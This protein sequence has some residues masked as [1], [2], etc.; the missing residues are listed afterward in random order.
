MLFYY[1]NLSG[2]A[3]WIR[4]SVFSNEY[5]GRDDLFEG[6]AIWKEKADSFLSAFSTYWNQANSLESVRYTAFFHCL[7]RNLKLDRLGAAVIADSL[8]HCCCSSLIDVV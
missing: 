7:L 6:K 1:L 3:I 8:D 5:S 4:S 2:H